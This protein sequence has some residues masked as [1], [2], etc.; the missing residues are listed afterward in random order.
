[1]GKLLFRTATDPYKRPKVKVPTRKTNALICNNISVRPV[2]IVT[3]LPSTGIFVSNCIRPVFV[4]A[5]HN[6]DGLL[7]FFNQNI[8]FIHTQ[9]LRWGGNTLCTCSN[10]A[11]SFMSLSP[12]STFLAVVEQ[13]QTPIL[14]SFLYSMHTNK[15]FGY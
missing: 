6:L 15:M 14:P 2:Y 1:M 13:M 7:F 12:P 3:L 8:N 11:F 10:P 4:C 5:L 9:R